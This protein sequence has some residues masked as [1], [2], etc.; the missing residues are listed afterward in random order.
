MKKI[1]CLDFDGVVH[2]YTSGWK[3]PRTIPDPPVDGVLVFMTRLLDHGYRVAIFSSRGR[4]FGGRRAM[5]AWLKEHA[6][7][8]FYDCPAGSGLD[9]VEFP[10][11]KPPAHL[12][13]DDRAITF[14]GDFPDLE[15]VAEFKPW[16][17][18]TRVAA[19]IRLARGGVPPDERV[20]FAGVRS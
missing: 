5:R 3:G 10:R 6:G 20:P 17:A 14:A 9:R 2:S 4:Y 15:E 18:E 7:N 11:H 8:M 16:H 13:I 19:G 1:V 12:S